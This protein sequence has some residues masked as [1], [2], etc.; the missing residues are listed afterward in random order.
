[1][2]AGG[3][4][5]RAHGTSVQVVRCCRCP[6]SKIAA[7]VR[8]IDRLGVEQ[9]VAAAQAALDLVEFKLAWEFG[10]AQVAAGLQETV[11]LALENN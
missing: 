6:A 10:A 11:A 2:G 4:T 7:P 3:R 1:M 9:G 5:K 8:Q